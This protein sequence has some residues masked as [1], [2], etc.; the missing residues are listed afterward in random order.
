MPR[1]EQIPDSFYQPEQPY[2]YEYD[3]LPVK[4]LL[5]KVDLINRAVDNVSQILREAVGTQGT[6]ANRLDQSLEANG[7]LKPQAI[8]QSLHNIGAHIDGLFDD[9]SGP[10]YYVRMTQS[11]RDKLLL[12]ADEANLITIQFPTISAIST[13]PVIFEEGNLE[14]VNSSTISWEFI[15]PNKVALHTNQP[16]EFVRNNF[17]DI[18]PVHENLSNPNYIDFKVNSIPS[19]FIED[20]L[21]VYVNGIRLSAT[22]SIYVPPANGGNVWA[23]T[24]FTASPE[25]GTFTMSRALSP[26]DVIR[27]DFDL[28]FI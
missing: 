13:T 4:S 9:G 22:E 3:N 23:A 24:S 16:M 27:I 5:T 25:D 12:V 14:F 15:A 17:Y 8:D 6:L 10:E 1:I 20:S 7:H 21:R 28:S 19:A 18:T 2:H 11:E 26:D